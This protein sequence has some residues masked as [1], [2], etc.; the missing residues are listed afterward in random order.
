MLADR[1]AVV[2]AGAWI[3][4]FH[5][6]NLF[7]CLSCG[8]PRV[9]GGCFG[10]GEWGEL[11]STQS[12]HRLAGR[13][14]AA[15]ARN[16]GAATHPKLSRID[17]SGFF[18]FFISWGYAL[19]NPKV[20]DRPQPGPAWIP[21]KVFKMVAT[22]AQPYVQRSCDRLLFVIVQFVPLQGIGF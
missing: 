12:R 5:Y 10:K 17:L 21:S 20:P 15:R 4:N 22:N 16:R 11:Q 18:L 7:R 3:A 13:G 9:Q 8:S 1:Q 14:R 19:K 6:G 2:C